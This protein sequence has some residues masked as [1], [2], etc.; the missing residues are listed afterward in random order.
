MARRRWSA[1]ALRT[2]AWLA[3]VAS[4]HGREALARSGVG[5]LTLIDLDHVAESN[6]NRQI[7]A[8]EQTLGQAKVLAMAERV[9]GINSQCAVR[10][11]E[12]FASPENVAELLPACDAVI[13]AID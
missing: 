12:E 8:L 7:H 9:A 4:V 6:I 13:D 3:S 2:Y 11:I 10:T 5:R 1:Y